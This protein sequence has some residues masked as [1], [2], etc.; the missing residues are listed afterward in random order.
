MDLSMF[1]S[2]VFESR[3]VIP[4]DVFG[5]LIDL[6]G[7]DGFEVSL[8]ITEFRNV[9]LSGFNGGEV[10][11]LYNVEND[12]NLSLIPYENIPKRFRSKLLYESENFKFSGVRRNKVWIMPSQILFPK[13]Y[14]GDFKD[15]VVSRGISYYKVK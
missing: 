9:K 12:R 7:E 1:I 5:K 10:K 8:G 11:E 3:K 4:K 2:D 15:F 14:S 13:D 6:L